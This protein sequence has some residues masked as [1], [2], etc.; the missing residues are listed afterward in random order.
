MARRTV[1]I[2]AATCGVILAAVLSAVLWAGRSALPTAGPPSTPAAGSP[3]TPPSGSPSARG[4]AK[5]KPTAPLVALSSVDRTILQDIRYATPHNFTGRV[6]DGYSQPV[7]LLTAPGARALHHAQQRLLRRGYSLKVYDCYR[8]QRAVDRFA[9][10]AGDP[11]KDTMKAEFHPEVPRSRLFA[12]GYIA[13]R[14][15][16]S[17][18]STV[19]L[20][21]VALPAKPVRAYRPGER[22]TSCFAPRSQ[23]FPDASIDMGTGFDC[24]DPRAN[25]LDRRIVGTP[26]ENRLMLSR[27]MR[28]AGF[29]GIPEEWWHFTYRSEPYPNTYFDVPVSAESLK[30]A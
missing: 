12:D 3:S 29:T 16:H 19:D 8:P 1:V 30:H 20:T 13:R 10:W 7:C 9:A 27:A 4:R 21:I 25:T 5:R 24:F 18:G 22:L 28:E 6:V 11:G 14:S 26:H 17:R 23:R 15:G 2:C